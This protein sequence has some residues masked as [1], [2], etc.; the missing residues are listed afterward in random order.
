ML[1][2]QKE[3]VFKNPISIFSKKPKQHK[4]ITAALL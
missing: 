4:K 1:S 2:I 3:K